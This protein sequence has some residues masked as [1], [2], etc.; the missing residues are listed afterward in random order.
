MVYKKINFKAKNTTARK[1]KRWYV[2]ASATL[3]FIGKTGIKFGTTTPGAR[4][5]KVKRAFTKEVQRI[6]NRNVLARKSNYIPDALNI[7]SPLANTWDTYNIFE[8][9]FPY[10]E[11]LDK[12]FDQ[13]VN[14]SVN[15]TSIQ[16]QGKISVPTFF[17]TP[18]YIKF[19]LVSHTKK[20]TTNKIWT[21]GNGLG[22]SD[23][24]QAFDDESYPAQIQ[25][26]FDKEKDVTKL[27]E[28]T[29]ILQPPRMTETSTGNFVL[30]Q[31]TSTEKFLDYTIPFKKHLVFNKD[32]PTGNGGYFLKNK[33]FYLLHASHQS[34]VA[35]GNALPFDLINTRLKINYT[36]GK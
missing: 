7:A 15:T 14:D 10:Q 31:S 22:N 9:M 29:I 11:T 35:T 13:R 2:D 25:S 21:S 12:D 20:I 32:D 16:F 19:W 30:T 5:T 26:M 3:P 36:D 33:Q 18:L 28:D 17:T 1:N 27:W 34:D 4:N 23:L 8:E 6:V 24:L